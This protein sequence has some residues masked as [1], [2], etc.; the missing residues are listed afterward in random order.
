M[1]WQNPLEHSIEDLVLELGDYL[2]D[3]L[4]LAAGEIART[5]EVCRDFSKFISKDVHQALPKDYTV[6]LQLH[7]S[8][9]QNE[10][11]Y[12]NMLNHI[13]EFCNRNVSPDQPASGNKARKEAK[14]YH[15]EP[16]QDMLRD[17]FSNPNLI[18]NHEDIDNAAPA[19]DAS[20]DSGDNGI[21]DNLSEDPFLDFNPASTPVPTHKPTDDLFDHFLDMPGSMP[22]PEPKSQNKLSDIF[23]S[24]PSPD[25]RTR[26]KL[27]DIFNSTP[28]PEKKPAATSAPV[29]SK[30]ASQAERFS[31][32]PSS[33]NHKPISESFNQFDFSLDDNLASELNHEDSK[34]NPKIDK[35]SARTD[36][37]TQTRTSTPHRRSDSIADELAVGANTANASIPRNNELLKGVD[38]ISYDFSS[39][40]IKKLRETEQKGTH[41]YHP[42][43][44]ILLDGGFR[45]WLYDGKYEIDRPLPDPQKI[46]PYSC[47]FF[48]RYL[49]PLG[50]AIISFV[51]T[52]SV[53]Q[54]VFAMGCFFGILTLLCLAIAY[55]EIRQTQQNTIQAT[56]RAYYNARAGYC[57]SL[58]RSL[59]ARESNTSEIDLSHLWKQDSKLPDAIFQRFKSH[60]APEYTIVNG[61]DRQN[62]VIALVVTEDAYYII[63]MALTQDRWFILD[64]SLGKHSLKS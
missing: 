43:S 1:A 32:T 37:T 62:A 19:Y 33:A 11:D 6:Y 28:I 40:S 25:Q 44:G 64:P 51:L 48:E 47:S 9:P 54:F 42:N 7:S 58:G 2:A 17:L 49:I 52:I 10:R 18:P 53:G 59:L 16:S 14:T 15:F 3:E 39:N 21:I 61:S 45:K 22:D 56:I 29:L 41:D 8:T 30:I 63:P 50:P 46:T 55:P 57:V 26:S 12:R 38:N 60:P 34:E 23:N 27:N 36:S 5:Q 35:I 31:R 13:Q 24:T 4:H 20:D